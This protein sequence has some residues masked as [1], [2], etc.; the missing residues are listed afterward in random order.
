MLDIKS[1]YE[2]KGWVQVPNCIPVKFIEECRIHLSEVVLT[3]AKANGVEIHDD[4]SLNDQ[5]NF[6]CNHDRSLG[7]M[8]YDCM[9]YHPI[10]LEMSIAPGI[11][12]T[13]KK[14][15][16]SKMLFHVYDQM[17]FRIDR[18][19]EDQFQ[20]KWHQDYWYNNTSIN[21]LT[22]WVPLFDTP[23]DMGPMQIIDG[24]HKEPSKVRI[25]PNFKTKWDQNRLITLAE[26]IPYDS[27]HCE[28]CN[29]GSA[30][31][32]N[33]LTMHRSGMNTSKHNR[34]TFVLRYADLFD[35]ELISKRWKAGIMPGH[36]SLIKQR[37]ELISNLDELKKYGVI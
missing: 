15:L 25:D 12:E 30:I 20:L 33:A 19:D 4:T 5:F 6:L 2:E 13:I 36:V 27:G 31:F 14:L 37:P 24:S 35:P 32:M 8:V 9:R 7:G 23:L 10:M 3:I 16:N 29:S 18:K 34:F 26:D 21:A 11:L 22:V 28:P 1:Q 17:Q